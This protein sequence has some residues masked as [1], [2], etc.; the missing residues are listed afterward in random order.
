MGERLNGDGAPARHPAHPDATTPDGTGPASSAPAVPAGVLD[1]AGVRA[2]LAAA[3]RAERVDAEGELR[4]VAAF[5]AARETGAHQARTRRRDDWRPGGQRWSARSMKTAFSLFAASLTLGGVAVAG[6]GSGGSAPQEPAEDRRRTAPSG[7][8]PSGSTPAPRADRPAGRASGTG[9]ARLAR[10]LTAADIEAHC[11]A[12][13]RVE[14]RGRA[15]AA[16]AWERLIA[17]AGGPE[18]VSGYCARR[19]TDDR[20]DPR[21]PGTPAN[22]GSPESPES[23]GN[24]AVPAAPVTPTARPADPGSQA[25]EHRPD[26][27]TGKQ[28]GRH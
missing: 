5:R 12:Y 18:G 4:A 7:T 11:R 17:A 2:L 19:R 6:I 3:V 28:P 1:E 15:M 24:P 21:G 27:D 22:P 13:E 20:A 25:E 10:P 14:G 16:Q 9:P 8:A 26:R 23:R